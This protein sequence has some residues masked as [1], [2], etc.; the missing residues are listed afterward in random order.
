[1]SS[2]RPSALPHLP[3]DVVLLILDHIDDTAGPSTLASLARVSRSL[4]RKFIPL[5][6]KSITLTQH[7]CSEFFYGLSPADTINEDEREEWWEEE[8]E[9]KKSAVAR[10]LAMLGYVQNVRLEDFEAVTICHSAIATFLSLE[11]KAPPKSWYD[12][13]KPTDDTR[14]RRLLFHSRIPTNVHLS[15]NLLD[16]LRTSE[17]PLNTKTWW[18]PLLQRMLRT[19]GVLSMEQPEGPAMPYVSRCLEPICR[20]ICP[21]LLVLDSFE[22]GGLGSM[23]SASQRGVAIRFRDVDVNSRINEQYFEALNLI[24][25]HM[26]RT[27]K[28]LYYIIYNVSSKGVP[29]S[30]G[31]PKHK[32]VP[33]PISEKERIRVSIVSYA[34]VLAAQSPRQRRVKLKVVMAGVESEVSVD[35]MRNDLVEFM[36]TG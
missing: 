16:S 21:R 10:R 26:R 31:V 34:F 36:K 12:P 9:D 5:L 20:Q 2:S 13:R 18:I 4:H 30:F 24:S 15:S 29:V 6:Y 14:S 33:V 17:A 25:I 28:P 3:H 35:K 22:E 1:M 19:S 32:G 8:L 7:N 11:L 27:P 23:L